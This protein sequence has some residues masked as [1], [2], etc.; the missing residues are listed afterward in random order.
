MNA[1]VTP[2]MS[3]RPLGH[4]IVATL[5]VA[6]H[7]GA[8]WLLEQGLHGRSTGDEPALPMIVVG[9][10][11]P[12]LATPALAI[13]QAAPAAPQPVRPQPEPR[14][15][16][17][18]PAQP[19]P[20]TSPL[21]V[22]EPVAIASHEVISEPNSSPIST[23]SMGEPQGRHAEPVHASSYSSA[24]AAGATTNPLGAM[25]AP[26]LEL[27]SA[28]ASYLNNPPPRYPPMSRRLG[29]QGTVIVRARI[30]V[31]GSA[32]QAKI[33]TSSGFARLDQTALQAVLSWRYVPGTRNGVP[34]AMWFNIPIQFVLE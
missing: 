16:K 32:T 26:R 21:A 33:N 25:A 29:E 20:A 27:P 22:A 23:P 7:A 11:A 9:L 2:S 3:S 34:E 4:L 30:E 19:T 31:H 17:P 15:P 5:V 28:T 10:M 6:A 24:S 12:E 1:L 13:A 14:P 18:G 8:L